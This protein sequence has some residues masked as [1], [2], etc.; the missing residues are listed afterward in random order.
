MDHHHVRAGKDHRRPGALVL[1]TGA[2]LSVLLFGYLSILKLPQ[3]SKRAGIS[4]PDSVFFGYDA[5]YLARVQ[6]SLDAKAAAAYTMFHYTWDIIF[7]VLFALTLVLFINRLVH[8]LKARLL[9][10]L[11]PIIYCVADIAE[12]IAVEAALALSP[13]TAAAALLAS[14]LT[15]LK[16][17]LFLVAL[18]SLVAA[19]WVNANETRAQLRA[20]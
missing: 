3:L 16:F 1:G 15:T 10:W 20:S 13:P 5:N 2:V 19:M 9:L 4:M 17:G 12:N 7:P 11:F 8:S 14:T 18:L 6:N